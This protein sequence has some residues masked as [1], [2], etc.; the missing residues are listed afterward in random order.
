MCTYLI[1]VQH[2]CKIKLTQVNLS[3][4]F[5]INE[6]HFFVKA[7][8]FEYWN[9]ANQLWFIWDWQMSTHHHLNEL[10]ILFPFDHLG[11]SLE[12]FPK[13]R[14]CCSGINHRECFKV[15]HCFVGI[16]TRFPPLSYR[17]TWQFITPLNGVRSTWT[18]QH[19]SLILRI[20]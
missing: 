2:R 7:K 17:R 20:I 14:I 19:A 11:S 8:C 9:D 12:N 13:C 16:R 5:R 10:Y 3:Q 6:T 15:S 4:C 18:S 1:F